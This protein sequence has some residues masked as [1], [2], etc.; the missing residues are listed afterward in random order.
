MEQM[1]WSPYPR[2]RCTPGFARGQ[3]RVCPGV[4]E[5][6]LSRNTSQSIR[7]HKYA[8]VFYQPLPAVAAQYVAFPRSDRKER[9][10]EYVIVILNGS[11]KRGTTGSAEAGWSAPR[12]SGSMHV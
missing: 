7:L 4:K 5:I 3:S 8:N 10:A 11:S 9:S 12:V 1:A 6:R 2:I